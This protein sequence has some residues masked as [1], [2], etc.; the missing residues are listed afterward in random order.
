MTQDVSGFSFAIALVMLFVAACSPLPLLNA[1]VP[2]DG[3][4][5]IKD[6]A[7]GKQPRQKLDV[8]SP[9][10]SSNT[11]PL[12][13]VVFFYGGSWEQGNRSHYRFVAEALTS[14]GFIAVVPDYRLYP[15]V[16]FPDF[17]YDAAAAVRW[18][19]DNIAHLDGDAGRLFVM[20]HS[21][22]AYIAAMLALDAQY[23]GDVRMTPG[24]LRGMIGLA[25][26]YDF[27]PLRDKNLQA[28]FGPVATRNRTQP[29][30]Y[31]TGSNPPMLLLTGVHDKVVNPGNTYRLAAKIKSAG[32]PVQVIKFR[33]YGHVQMAA[34]LAAPLRGDDA[35]L[36]SVA[37]FIRAP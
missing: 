26:P 17:L 10:V 13:V 16:K 8:Y 6:I 34:K 4:T 11:G 21:A 20:G 2:T 36:N 18:V 23:L 28:I 33:N 31:V 1:A 3:Y 19:H 35:L 30:N 15:D 5:V 9:R 14:Q 12:P 7:Y 27:L 32:G 37:D 22:G 24:D 29:I 25:G